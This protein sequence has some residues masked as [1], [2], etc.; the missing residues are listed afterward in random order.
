MPSSGA[1]R[2]LKENSSPF[3][4]LRVSGNFKRTLGWGSAHAEALEAGGG[5]LQQAA[6]GRRAATAGFTLMELLVSMLLMS[7]LLTMVVKVFTTQ[8][9]AY[10]QE[11]LVSALEEHLRFGMGSI[12]D[13]LRNSGYGVPTTNLSNWVPWVSG[14]TT[15][16]LVSGS[17]PATISIASCFQDVATLTSRASAGA[18]TLALTSAVSGKAL[19][20]LLNTTNERLI[21]ID[22]SLNAQIT[23]VTSTSV[24]I[25][26][27]PVTSG[28]QGVARSYGAGTPVCRVDVKTFSIT[29]DAT[30]GV[31]WLGVDFNQGAGV[32]PMAEGLSNLAITTTLPN[33]YQLTLTARTEQV[34]PMSNGYI[35]RSLSTN[36]TLKNKN[37]NSW[38]LR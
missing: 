34:D 23:A 33:Q 3:E 30:T 29:T 5:V 17:N 4:S 2:L 24:N 10:I 28:A 35:T 1:N 26:T 25:D 15:N 16:P 38:T 20:D 11:D 8:N 22:G 19:T 36:V 6:Q 7:L 32:Q 18:T 12:T 27:D 9:K 37:G 13:A 14:F 31:P 21:L